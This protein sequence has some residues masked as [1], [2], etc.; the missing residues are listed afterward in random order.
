MH[1]LPEKMLLNH[2]KMEVRVSKSSTI[3]LYNNT[4]SVNSSLIGEKVIVYVFSRILEV[5]YANNR[6]EVIPRL[7]G[8]EKH[9]I[10]YRHIIDWLIRKPGAFDNYKF[11]DDLYPTTYF[12]ITYDNFVKD[13]PANA[14]KDYLKLL[15]LAKYE[16]ESTVND[17]LVYLIN[18]NY[19]I[20]Y[21]VIEQL[22]KLK[23]ELP[24]RTEVSITN[25]DLSIYNSLIKTFIEQGE[26]YDK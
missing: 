6:L 17:I 26:T 10:N 1:S 11:R 4:Y 13:K 12:R 3:R 21:F 2:K 20:S 19:L 25:P 22:V 5:W 8:T 18:N 9:Y 23:N 15:Y 16:G 7:K 14:V 24:K